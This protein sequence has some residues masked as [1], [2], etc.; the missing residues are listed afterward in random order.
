MKRRMLALLLT[1]AMALTVLPGAVVAAEDA[2]DVLTYADLMEMN[3]SIES[4]KRASA[5]KEVTIADMVRTLLLWTGMTEEQLGSFPD[6][7]LAQARSM[8]MIAEDT[9]PDAVCTMST[10][11]KMKSV[12][13]VMYDALHADKRKPLFMNGMAQP[14]FPYTTGSVESGYSNEDSDIIRYVVYVET[15]YDTDDD[16]KLDLVKAVVQ[17]PRAAMEGDYQAATIFEARPYIAGCNNSKDPGDNLGSEPYDISKMYSRPAARVPAG[18]ATTRAVAASADSADWHY[19]DSSAQPHVYEDLEWYD[20]YLVRGYAVVECAGLGTNGSDGF[21]TCGTD[22]EIDALKCVI[23]WLHGD[24]VAYTDKTG[25]IAISADWSSGKVGMTGRSYAGTTQFG[26]ATTGVEGLETIVP[27]AGIASWYEYTN[28][29][30]ILTSGGISFSDQLAWYCSSRYLD[31]T[32]YATIAEKYGNYL[33]QIRQ[34]QLTANGDYSDHWKVRDYTLDAENIKCP[35][36]IVHGLNDDNVRTKEFD[37]MYQAYQKA[38]VNVKLLLHQ[39]AHLTPSYEPSHMEFYIDG[40]SYNSVLNRWFSHYLYGVENGAEDMA[41]VTVQDNSDGSVWRT[42]DNWDTD[43]EIVLKDASKTGTTTINSDYASR[44][45]T[46][47]N[48]RDRL[49]TGATG[50]SSMYAMEV[51]AD[52][53]IQGAVA[54]NFTASAD[55]DGAATATAASRAAAENTDNDAVPQG[56]EVLDYDNDMATLGNAVHGIAT[57]AA[58]LPLAERDG[59]MVSAML[60]DIAPAGTTFPAFNTQNSYVPKSKGEGGVWRGGGLVNYDYAELLTSDVTYKIIARGWMDLCNPD[61]GYDSASASMDSRISLKPGENHDY[62]LYLQPN[63]YTV[64]AGHKLALVIYTYEP[65]K[66]SYTQNYRI[67]LKNSSVNAVIPVNEKPEVPEVENPFTDVTEGS[68]YYDAVLWATKNGIV[69]GTTSTTFEPSSFCTRAAIVTFL[70]R[71]A[72]SPD[73]SDVE[74][75]FRDVTEDAY[76]ADAVKWGASKG[77]VA[78][79]SATTFAPNAPCTRGQVAAFLYRTVGS[80]DASG[81]EMPFTDVAE[82][83]YYADAIKWA[84]QNNVIYGTSDTT[85]APESTC[86]RA[87]IVAMLYRWL[88]P[89]Q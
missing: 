75:T 87:D 67:S 69:Y 77:I 62:T 52:T 28:S 3:Q 74:L 2:D 40:E 71:A 86:I 20:Y 23:E 79:T 82:G 54:V 76:Y 37:L 34:N 9:D 65:G 24:R 89:T 6:D 12:A 80:P 81:A 47:Q 46:E 4:E 5:T 33:Y 78:G 7:Y 39:D 36:L 59:L 68:Y 63:L 31:P 16:G 50:V 38:G 27:V 53:V 51:K 30:G 29:Q 61:A 18:T 58:N 35:A 42:Y 19:W 70:Y 41:A 48:W 64:K 49:A 25:N 10:Y 22:L 44:G 43:E 45:I 83:V 55:N 60:V 14:I 21:Q 1:L 66:A 11:R 72:G 56:T 57:Y 26:L 88:V 84:Y 8:G 17:L 32:D 85:Y 13:S 73:V 15:N